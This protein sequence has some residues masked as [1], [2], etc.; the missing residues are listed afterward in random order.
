MFPRIV[1]Q[2]V[3]I[4]AQIIGKAF[5][6]SYKRA[7]QEAATNP[8]I[9]GSVAKKLTQQITKVEAEQILDVKKIIHTKI[10]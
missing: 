8:N 5:I 9:A 1:A 2:L 6:E 4:G 10:Y 7:A 3:M